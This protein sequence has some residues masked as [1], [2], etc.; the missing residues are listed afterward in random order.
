MYQP[1]LV[2]NACKFGTHFARPHHK[3]QRRRVAAVV[4]A[5]VVRNENP[6]S[7]REN[8]IKQLRDLSKAP[9]GPQLDLCHEQ[10]LGSVAKGHS[11]LKIVT[12]VIYAITAPTKLRKSSTGRSFSSATGSG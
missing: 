1:K 3:S 6:A 9:A 2:A 8:I 4:A 5:V 7:L 11:T 10:A 12:R